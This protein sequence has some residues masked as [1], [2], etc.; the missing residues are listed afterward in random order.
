M[1]WQQFRN[2]N[3]I[4]S[5]ESGYTDCYFVSFNKV[6]VQEVIDYLNN[7][8]IET[9]EEA[10]K[11]IKTLTDYYKCNICQKDKPYLVTRSGMYNFGTGI[12]SS[13]LKKG[14]NNYRKERNNLVGKQIVKV[15]YG[16]K[17]ENGFKIFLNDNI[18]INIEDGE[19]GDDNSNIIKGSK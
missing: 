5:I 13:C 7:N 8:N 16:K 15:D 3:A 6:K 9:Q 19:Y 17:G 4:R 18:I 2:C 10:W 12:C 14:D 11:Y 1:K